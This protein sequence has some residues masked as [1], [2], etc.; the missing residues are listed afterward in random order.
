MLLENYR[1]IFRRK[2][3]KVLQAVT[4]CY[5]IASLYILHD[6][7][8][9]PLNLNFF[10]SLHGPSRPY[11]PLQQMYTLKYSEKR[12]FPELKQNFHTILP[13]RRNLIP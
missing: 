3:Y 9:S 4:G 1:N 6:Y 2:C 8:T 10:L 7:D 5:N 13:F 11:K 12:F